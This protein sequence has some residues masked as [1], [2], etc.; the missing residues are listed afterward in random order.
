MAGGL[1]ALVADQ[2]RHRRDR[3]HRAEVGEPEAEVVGVE[4]RRVC[5]VALP[6]DPDR[7]EQ[8]GETQESSGG[9]VGDQVLR[10]LRDRHD[11]D[12][13]EEQLEPAGVTLALVRQSAQLR[14]LEPA[15]LRRLGLAEL[16]PRHFRANVTLTTA[17]TSFSSVDVS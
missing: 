7:H 10:Q 4:P 6:G 11:E 12:E 13:I 15:G 14:W 5:H 9:V 3:E 8:G 1:T 2:H 17:V 16:N